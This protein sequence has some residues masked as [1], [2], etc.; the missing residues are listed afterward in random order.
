MICVKP[1][2]IYSD[3]TLLSIS[4]TNVDGEIDKDSLARILTDN[5]TSSECEEYA[6]SWN[7]L[8]SKQQCLIDFCEMGTAMDLTYKRRAVEI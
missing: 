1:A 8:W 7:V 4:V 2:K 6:G 3:S 5:S